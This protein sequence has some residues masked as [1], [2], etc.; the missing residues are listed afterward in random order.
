[1]ADSYLGPPLSLRSSNSHSHFHIHNFPFPSSLLLSFPPPPFSRSLSSSFSF[2][3]MAPVNSF[4]NNSAH[5]CHC[6]SA[7]TTSTAN[8]CASN[9][10]SLLVFSGMLSLLIYLH[11]HALKY[12]KLIFFFKKRGKD[13]ICVW[14]C[15]GP[16]ISTDLF[17]E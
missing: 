2:S 3:F 5:C 17:I 11:P 7:S 4:L 1:M 9:Q 10:T 15:F 6:S 8:N 14:C 13:F 12:L 16:P